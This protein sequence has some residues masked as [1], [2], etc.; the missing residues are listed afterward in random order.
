MKRIRVFLTGG[1]ASLAQDDRIQEVSALGD[2]VKVARGNGH[3][4][5]TYSGESRNLNG[6]TLPVFHWCD[7]TRLAE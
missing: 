3:E 1:P 4:H 6:S 2:K 5:F 7:R